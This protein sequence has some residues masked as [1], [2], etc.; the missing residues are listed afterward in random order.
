MQMKK[1]EMQV[2]TKQKHRF[3]CKC[4]PGEVAMRIWDWQG[5]IKGLK[6]VNFIFINWKVC[7]SFC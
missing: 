7:Y 4:E 1:M 2:K 6:I 3:Q 5:N